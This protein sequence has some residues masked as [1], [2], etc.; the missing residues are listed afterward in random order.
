M[1]PSPFGFGRIQVDQPE[2]NAAE[3]PTL[4]SGAVEVFHNRQRGRQIDPRQP[5]SE[6]AALKFGFIRH[7]PGDLKRLGKQPEL[8]ILIGDL[9]EPTQKLLALAAAEPRG[10]HNVQGVRV[11]RRSGLGRDRHG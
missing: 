4:I 3:N 1:I 2:G 10:R 8:P 6:Q 5:G 11:L 7:L 9:P